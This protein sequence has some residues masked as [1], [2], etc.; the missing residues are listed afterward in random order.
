MKYLVYATLVAISLTF[1]PSCAGNK[2]PVGLNAQ[3]TH[4]WYRT[5][6]EKGLNHV[7]DA[8]N[9]AHDTTPP[10]IDAATN[11]QIVQWHELV[12]TIIHDQKAGW[13]TALDTAL[14]GLQARLS[15]DTWALI[16]PYVKF[17]QN[18]LK[19]VQL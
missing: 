18:L 1:T 9:D 6:V 17:V 19:Q 7:R 2:P 13:R 15:P 4:D 12:I 3:A 14:G 16:G 10:L 11:L 5:E 8:A